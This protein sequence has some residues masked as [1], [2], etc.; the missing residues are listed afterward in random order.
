MAATSDSH[1]A[2][3]YESGGGDDDFLD[4]KFTK[5]NVSWILNGAA[6]PAAAALDRAGP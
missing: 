3:L 5:F 1:I 6:E 2:A 4:I